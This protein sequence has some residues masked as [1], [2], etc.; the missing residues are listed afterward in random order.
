MNKF[1]FVL[2]GGICSGKSTFA[3]KLSNTGDFVIISKD[4]CIYESDMLYRRNILKSWEE[5]REEYVDNLNDLNVIFDETLRVGKLDKIKAKG[6]VII[7]ITLEKDIKIREQR[8]TQRNNLN[9]HYISELSAITN[10]DLNLC[11]QEE[12]RGYWRNQHFRDSIPANKQSRFDKVLEQ[13]YLLGSTFLKDEE[14]NPVCYEHIDYIIG[15]DKV[16]LDGELDIDDI[17]KNSTSYCDY[18]EQWAKKIKYCIWDVGGVFYHYSLERLNQWCSQ[19]TTDLEEWEKKKGTFSFN[20]Y[21]LGYISFNEFCVR[22]CKYYNIQYSLDY[23]EQIEQC[24]KLGIGEMY[25]ETE[26]AINYLRNKGITNCVL[27]NALPI[28]A[29]EKNYAELINPIHRFYSFIF[30]ELKPSNKIYTSMQRKLNAPLENMIFI[31]DKQRNISEA[32]DLGIYSILFQNGTIMEKLQ[33][34][35]D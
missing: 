1:A 24:L 15:A 30:H 34:I 4:R 12:R 22:I 6:Y 33:A 21:M 25:K 10:I 9:K 18:K 27:S 23:N 29:D 2:V 8:L 35:F 14:P 31:D 7:A 5:I 28:L 17:I 3:N 11:N 32:I 20:D 26:C 19:K 13:L 16:N